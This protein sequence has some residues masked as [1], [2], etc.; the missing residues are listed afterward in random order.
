MSS[1]P[2]FARLERLAGE[3]L[4]LVADVSAEDAHLD[5]WALAVLTARLERELDTLRAIV[6]SE[7][8]R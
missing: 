7:G 1:S 4:S 2:Q 3:L 6:R 8:A 5:P